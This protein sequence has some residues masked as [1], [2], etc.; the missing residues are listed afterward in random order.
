MTKK[1]NSEEEEGK[2]IQCVR[3]CCFVH[4]WVVVLQLFFPFPHLN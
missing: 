4:R 2:N 1:R 3:F